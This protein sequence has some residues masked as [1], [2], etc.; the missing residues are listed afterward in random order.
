EHRHHRPSRPRPRLWLHQDRKRQRDLLPRHGRHG[1]HALR[2]PDRG[3]DRLVRPVAG[4]PRPR[5]ARRQR[6]AGL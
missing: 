4:H 2:Q 1:Q 5:R 6:P 3:P